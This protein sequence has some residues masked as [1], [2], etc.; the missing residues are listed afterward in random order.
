MARF[1]LVLLL[2]FSLPSKLLSA[3]CSML[4][5]ETFT[6]T[7]VFV[8][9][10][11]NLLIE[12]EK[13]PV[14]LSIK[15][16]G[17]ANQKSLVEQISALSLEHKVSVQMKATHNNGSYSMGVVTLANGSVLNDLL[18]DDKN[19]KKAEPTPD[20][21][22]EQSATGQEMFLVNNC[23][24][25]IES[26]S[27]KLGFD[28]MDEIGNIMKFQKNLVSEL[29]VGLGVKLKA[30]PYE[31]QE[32]LTEPQTS[33]MAAFKLYSKGLTLFDNGNYEEALESFA[34]AVAEDPQ[35][36]AASQYKFITPRTNR[37]VNEVMA[38]AV[39]E[40]QKE[41]RQI[42]KSPRRF[43]LKSRNYSPPNLFCQPKP[44]EWQSKG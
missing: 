9:K 8:M 21:N 20:E 19:L 17:V 44:S 27:I 38:E 34:G 10:N 35:F 7:V 29:V 18:K 15:L 30:L 39:A 37:P 2:F 42:E 3:P 13:E 40:A 32:E 14:R 41:A 24:L 26:Q 22:S 36:G 31:L 6:G 11:G 1:F 33:S 12:L 4:L 23:I 16:L 25:N 28:G 43:N 5:P